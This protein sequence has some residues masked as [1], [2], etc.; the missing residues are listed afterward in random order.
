MQRRAPSELKL[1]FIERV[2]SSSF[3]FNWTRDR[4]YVA[5]IRDDNFFVIRRGV[6]THYDTLDARSLAG[7]EGPAC[8][9]IR[10]SSS[11]PRPRNSPF[12]RPVS[13]NRGHCRN[14]AFRRRYS[15]VS[16][17]PSVAAALNREKS[18]EGGN[19]LTVIMELTN[20]NVITR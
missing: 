20:T 11:H 15:R 18:Q 7:L 1:A 16:L 4:R 8:G 12:R 13:R 10:P 14:A 2:L 6:I 17:V 19:S 3:R 9:S 5:L